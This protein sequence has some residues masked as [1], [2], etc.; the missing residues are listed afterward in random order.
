MKKLILTLIT[1]LL[2]QFSNAQTVYE[3]FQSEW[4]VYNSVSEKWEEQTINKNINID[5][6]LYKDVINIQ[7]KKPTLYRLDRDTKE[8][9]S[10]DGF[11]GYRYA[12]VECVEMTKCIV[13]IV[14]L[15]SNNSQNTLMI[16]VITAMDDVKINMR[17]YCK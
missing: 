7:A 6:V 13:D 8:S 10:G 12:A 17:Y 2:F 16:S 15:K 14:V 3:T 4:Y 9:I 1:A 5:I 11:T